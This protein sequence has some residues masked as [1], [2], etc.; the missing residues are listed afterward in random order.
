MTPE[1]TLQIIAIPS[2]KSS[3]ICEKGKLKSQREA[4]IK[5][6]CTMLVMPLECALRR[7]I[8]NKILHRK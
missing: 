1:I 8:R 6:I 4:F 2:F 5:L 7:I 3:M